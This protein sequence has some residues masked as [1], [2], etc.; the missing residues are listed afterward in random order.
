VAF[1][2]HCRRRTSGELNADPHTLAPLLKF[3]TSL[4]ELTEPAILELDRLL[5]VRGTSAV[6][7][8]A[9]YAMHF[10]SKVVPELSDELW[11]A[12][13]EVAGQR[14]WAGLVES[15]HEHGTAFDAHLQTR[16]R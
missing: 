3:C 9:E 16:A 10:H 7:E 2:A 4:L 13:A 12:L 15:L 6:H 14:H 8:A 11:T 1:C 5:V